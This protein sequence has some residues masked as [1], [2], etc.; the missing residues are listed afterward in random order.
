MLIRFCFH[1]HLPH[2]DW[3]SGILLFRDTL[4]RDRRGG[5]GR[6]KEHRQA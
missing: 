3:P 4:G 6:M 5:L 2:I 1:S